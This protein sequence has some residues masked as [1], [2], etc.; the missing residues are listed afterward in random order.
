MTS[1]ATMT[2]VEVTKRSVRNLADTYSF[3][4]GR[5]Y[6]AA[7]PLGW[8]AQGS[9]S[10]G[11]GKGVSRIVFRAKAFGRHFTIFHGPWLG[12]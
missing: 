10:L 6:F 2:V 12:D 3:E 7:D 9:K 4:R 8:S 5:A 11:L 1:S